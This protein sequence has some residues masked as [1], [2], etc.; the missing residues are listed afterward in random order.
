MNAKLLTRLCLA[1]SE[2]LATLCTKAINVIKTL[3][4]IIQ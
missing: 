1:T 3:I 2:P 4:V